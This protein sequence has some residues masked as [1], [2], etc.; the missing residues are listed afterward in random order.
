MITKETIAHRIEIENDVL[1]FE[2]KLN[3]YED[4][5][6]QATTYHRAPVVPGQQLKPLI[7]AVNNHLAQ[8]AKAPILQSDIDKINAIIKIIHTP[9]VC[10][11]YLAMIK[12]RQDEPAAQA[13]LELFAQQNGSQQ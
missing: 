10:A 11:A 13:T 1:F 4:G 9:E 6:L 5:V 3:L 12:A 2:L 7:D 8:M